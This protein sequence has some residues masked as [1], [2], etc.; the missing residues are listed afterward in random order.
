MY[1]LSM[2]D[3]DRMWWEY[4]GEWLLKNTNRILIIFN[5]APGAPNGNLVR[6][7]NSKE[8]VKMNFLNQTKIEEKKKA[9]VMHRIIVRNNVGVFDV[10]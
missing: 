8:K 5:Y 7:L 2:G 3:T 6:T 1:G 4:L 10:N 9:E